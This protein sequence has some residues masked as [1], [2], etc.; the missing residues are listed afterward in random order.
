MEPTAKAQATD[1][2]RAALW[3][4]R[5]V[6]SNAQEKRVSPE[7]G[8]KTHMSLLGSFTVFFAFRGW[9]EDRN[10]FWAEL[11]ETLINIDSEETRM[12]GWW[13]VGVGGMMHISC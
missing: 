7:G 13:G 4:R 9:E 8:G 10:M 11:W 5:C 1:G 3:G 6:C 12:A 2:A